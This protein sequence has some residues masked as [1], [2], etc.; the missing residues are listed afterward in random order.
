[1][2]TLRA[3][4]TPEWGST[5]LSQGENPLV[6]AGGEP[7]ATPL[8]P[9]ALACKSDVECR[10]VCVTALRDVQGQL[11]A[12][13][14]EDAVGRVPRDALRP[15]LGVRRLREHLCAQRVVEEE[16][17]GELARSRRADLEVDVHRA[18]LVPTGVDRRELRAA[19]RVGR[20]EAAQELLPARA[21]HIGV[22]TE[23]VAV[24]D[25][26]DGTAECRAR[27]AADARDEEVECE[28]RAGSHGA[29]AGI[30]PDVR[31]TELLVDEV[32]TLGQRGAHDA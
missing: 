5:C 19:R 18:A 13:L 31:A 2:N 32:R 12:A 30:R 29:G 7:P 11:P 27:A 20:L 23:R 8:Q 22:H 4:L 24:P 9:P 6:I 10:G 16:L 17:R 15:L 14:L 21:L 26:D 3:A 28:E 25:V 1:M